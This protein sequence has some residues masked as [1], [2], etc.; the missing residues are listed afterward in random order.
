MNTKDKA[1]L[2]ALRQMME[3]LS[4]AIADS[5]KLAAERSLSDNERHAIHKAAYAV[6][7]ALDV[8]NS[9]L[10]IEG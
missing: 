5:E 3:T 7:T 9:D 1:A 10:P 2:E 6:E 4:A 8:L